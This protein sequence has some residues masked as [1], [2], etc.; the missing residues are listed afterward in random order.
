MVRSGDEGGGALPEE[1][2][3]VVTWLL[4]SPA[5]VAEDPGDVHSGRRTS[6]PGKWQV[7]RWG[8]GD[9]RWRRRWGPGAHRRRGDRVPL[10]PG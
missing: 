3:R 4:V 8:A 10:G 2:A 1:L 6:A 5:Q 7:G 9:D